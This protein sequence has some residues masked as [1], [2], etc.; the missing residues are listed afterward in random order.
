MEYLIG[1]RVRWLTK[2]GVYAFGKIVRF[3]NDKVMVKARGNSVN[4]IVL[5][6]SAIIIDDKKVN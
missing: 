4:E 6:I 5:P 1:K 3:E 2:A